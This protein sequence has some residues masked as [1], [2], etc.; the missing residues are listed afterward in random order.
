MS[1][2]HP[3]VAPSVVSRNCISGICC[4]VWSSLYL[5]C[6]LVKADGWVS[7]WKAV[8]TILERVNVRARRI[9]NSREREREREREHN[10]NTSCRQKPIKKQHVSY[11]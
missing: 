2:S 11:Y 7:R 8:F 10:N 4:C 3:D 5:V 6:V 1:E 9:G